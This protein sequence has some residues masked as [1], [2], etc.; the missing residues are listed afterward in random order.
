MK[1]AIVTAYYEPIPA[2]RAFRA[3][4]LAKE[5]VRRGHEVTVY[6][7]TSVIQHGKNI[8]CGTEGVRLVN[9]D[10][11]RM[12]MT[13][14]V[15]KSKPKEAWYKPVV[16]K[17]LFYF[18]TNSGLKILLGLKRRLVF[19]EQY[20][21][22]ISIGLPFA[23]HWGVSAKIKGRNIARCYVADYGDPFS[24]FNQSIRVAKYF[25]WIE[26]KVVRKFDYIT[27][28][29]SRAI[30]SYLWLKDRADIRVIP[31]GFNYAE[32]RLAEY[33]R[34]PVPTFGYAG[35]F[36]SDIR[37]PANFF[38]FLCSLDFDFRFVI[39][40]N[41]EAVDSY[42]CIE[43]YIER[44][45]SKLELRHHIPRLDLIYCLS[46]MDFIVNVENATENQIPSKLVD[47]TL[48]K[49]PVFSLSQCHFDSRKFLRFCASQF[50]GEEKVDI[51]GFD[52]RRVANQFEKLLK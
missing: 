36:Y 32:V 40:T 43:P 39:Y 49:R 35:L 30:S 3:T 22:L 41:L 42:S 8:S 19:A 50:E 34:N 6:N 5:F 52:I 37:N 31:Q 24:R 4:E 1:V 28:P 45:G 12:H 47:Y 26:K 7:T 10:I 14:S 23:V 16:K 11:V 29:T 44:L 20:D 2:P 9:L 46:S 13:A 51:S 18:T 38:E 27:I 48:S 33:R 21:L 15:G 25:Q 17:L